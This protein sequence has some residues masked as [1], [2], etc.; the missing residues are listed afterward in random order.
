MNRLD[1]AFVTVIFAHLA[2]V[3]VHTVAHLELQIVPGAPDLAFVLSVIL[4]GPVASL[5]ILR[6]NRPL[7]SGLLAVLMAAAF[8]YGFQSHFLIAG[9]DNVSVVAANV[10]TLVFVATAIGLGVLELIGVG[11]A[12]ILFSRG[13][14]NPSG[15]LEPRT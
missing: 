6:F 14:R 8:A 10:W 15:R 7:A 3:L 2:V 4:V 13:V 5:P 1:A 12:A 11:V 9:P